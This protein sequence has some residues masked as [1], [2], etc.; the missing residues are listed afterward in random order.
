MPVISNHRQLDKFLNSRFPEGV[1][2]KR[3][4]H[5][6]SR[7]QIG[8]NA[9]IGDR[10]NERFDFPFD[11]GA[12]GEI[13]RGTD[14]AIRKDNEKRLGKAEAAERLVGTLLE[15]NSGDTPS[16]FLQD[17]TR[18]PSRR[19]GNVILTPSEMRPNTKVNGTEHVSIGWVTSRSASIGM[20][21]LDLWEMLPEYHS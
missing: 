19:L 2:A 14:Y 5:I 13:L 7:D 10:Q 1:E 21:P 16:R 15:N 6:L 8:F 17:G 3:G 4:L 20:I 18:R 9:D 11:S 12:F